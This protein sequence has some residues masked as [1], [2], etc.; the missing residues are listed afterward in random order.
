MDLFEVLLF[1]HLSY[2]LFFKLKRSICTCKK[3]H[4][5]DSIPHAEPQLAL[6][7]SILSGAVLV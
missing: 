3:C 1:I 4:G 5:S 6:H 2:L 7:F